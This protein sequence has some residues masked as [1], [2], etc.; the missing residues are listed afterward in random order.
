[1]VSPK[2]VHV[3]TTWNFSYQTYVTEVVKVMCDNWMVSFCNVFGQG[4][5]FI[6]NGWI[7]KIFAKKNISL[8]CHPAI[9]NDRS[10]KSH[11]REFHENG[12]EVHW[13][14]TSPEELLNWNVCLFFRMKSCSYEGIQ[15]CVWILC[16]VRVFCYHSF[17]LHFKYYLQHERACCIGY[18]KSG[19]RV[20]IFDTTPD[21][22]VINGLWNVLMR[23]FVFF[24]NL[25]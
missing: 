8:R 25:K 24:N 10:L 22:K 18:R 6:F 12:N 21:A 4:W 7:S 23:T 14:S 15:R 20:C 5:V 9:N 11:S 13:T 17:V 16:V 1:M 3:Q 2:K 19:A